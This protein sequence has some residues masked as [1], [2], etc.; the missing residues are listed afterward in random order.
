MD[1]TPI[2]L[3]T[4]TETEGVERVAGECCARVDRGPRRIVDRVFFWLL[5]RPGHFLK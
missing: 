1:Q 3:L 2:T 4:R 5:A